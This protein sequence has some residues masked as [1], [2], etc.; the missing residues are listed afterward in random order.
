MWCPKLEILHKNSRCCLTCL[1]TD[2]FIW[3]V[4]S[5]TRDFTKFVCI[6][7]WKTRRPAQ[8]NPSILDPKS[9]KTREYMQFAQVCY[10]DTCGKWGGT[11]SLLP[12]I[13]KR[14]L[15]SRFYVICPKTSRIFWNVEAQ[16]RDF[17]QFVWISNWETCKNW[18]V[19]QTCF[20]RPGNNGGSVSQVQR[21]RTPWAPK[22]N[23][24]VHFSDNSLNKESQT[25]D[26]AYFV[27]RSAN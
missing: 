8:R 20:L 17:T 10:R 1:K 3:K 26:F 2:K 14:P 12:H 4:E 13:Q 22:V 19:A 25:R 18:V 9:L 23:K 7:N 21:N 6:S 27:W 11:P 15:N 16:T 24:N 5:Q